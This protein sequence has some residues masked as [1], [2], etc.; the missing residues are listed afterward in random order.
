MDVGQVLQPGETPLCAAQNTCPAVRRHLQSLPGQGGA[1]SLSIT[2][3]PT[4]CLLGPQRSKMRTG[5]HW[6]I[7][8]PKLHFF[9]F[10][11][12]KITRCWR[13]GKL[14]INISVW[15][16]WT[17][18][19][20]GSIGWREKNIVTHLQMPGSVSIQGTATHNVT[21][22]VSLW[23]LRGITQGWLSGENPH[24]SGNKIVY[25]S[26]S[27]VVWRKVVCF[28][29]TETT[30][31]FTGYSAYQEEAMKH[32]LTPKSPVILHWL[33]NATENCFNTVFYCAVIFQTTPSSQLTQEPNLS[34]F[35]VFICF[36]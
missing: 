1:P 6:E 30:S 31:S 9:F 18:P 22:H 32:M 2:L 36:L 13:G 11:R 3:S 19:P 21:V 28:H 12:N 16:L 29:R 7:C 25:Y 17:P 35:Y 34:F 26:S 20:V 14:A 4:H 24:T 10:T 23:W 33:E 8:G 5:V 15:V 27:K